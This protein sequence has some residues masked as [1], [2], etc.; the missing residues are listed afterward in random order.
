MGIEKEDIELIKEHWKDNILHIDLKNKKPNF[1]EDDKKRLEENV[2]PFSDLDKLGRCGVAFT[3]I[4][5]NKLNSSEIPKFKGR[6]KPTAWKSIGC[7]RIEDGKCLYNRSHLIA[8]QFY[9]KKVD[10]RG[11]I[12][13]TRIFNVDGMFKYEDKVANYIKE[14]PEHHILYRVTPY[15]KEDNDLLP[16]SV[17]ME[18]L[19]ADDEEKLSYNVF[20]YNKQPGFTIDYRNGDVYSDFALS[21]SGKKA[22]NDIYVIDR[23]T[24]MFHKES[25]AIVR[26]I[27]SKRYFVGKKQVIEEKYCKC[28][29]C[30][31]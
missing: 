14:N 15:Y 21:L 6:T 16:Y 31:H 22:G 2:D 8:R 12:T 28:G 30:I 18:I 27:N 10:K 24:N 19:D 1:T 5:G 17:Q 11:L 7:D 20:V 3:C 4:V 26:D 29:I 9:I 13:G 25:C 23:A